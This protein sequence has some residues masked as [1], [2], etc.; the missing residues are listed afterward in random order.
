MAETEIVILLPPSEARLG[1]FSRG[2]AETAPSAVN[3]ETAA[4][5]PLEPG[6]ED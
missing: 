3:A 1:V 6:F 4:V 2:G 5:A